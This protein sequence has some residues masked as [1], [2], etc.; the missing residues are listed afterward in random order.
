[1]NLIEP[2][3]LWTAED[4]AAAGRG[5]ATTAWAAGGIS[6]DSRCL[7]EGDLF[8]ALQ[9]PNFDGHEFVAK[10]IDA[11]AAAAV[12][13]HEPNGV[14]EG[15]PLL[16]VAD[17]GA[18]LRALGQAGR[19]RSAA[20]VVGVTGS[21][22]KTGTKEMLALALGALEATGPTH[23]SQSSHN[24]AIGVPLTLARLPVGAAHAVVEMGMNHPGE[25]LPLSRMARPDVAVITNVEAVHLGFFENLDQIADAKAEIFAG[26]GGTGAA[27]LNQDNPYF[28]R[29]AA[30]GA[31][32]G[33]PRQVHGQ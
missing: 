10:A 24:N 14:G 5:N 17:T 4:A 32:G 29:L 3:M 19:D 28:G 7:S 18:A 2:T 6:I 26:M 30:A 9:G 16:M 22:G 11:G 20:T 1:M 21:V 12:V 25:I 33:R 8:F 15:A 31:R 27:V 13:A 23:A